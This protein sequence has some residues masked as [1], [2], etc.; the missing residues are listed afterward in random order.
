MKKT[1]MLAWQTSAERSF[2]TRKLGKTSGIKTLVFA[3]R[4]RSDRR[5][6]LTHFVNPFDQIASVAYATS[7][8]HQVFRTSSWSPFPTKWSPWDQNGPLSYAGG[9]A[10]DSGK[11]PLQ[12]SLTFTIIYDSDFINKEI[13]RTFLSLMMK[14]ILFS[15]N[16]S[17]RN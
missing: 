11:T 12:F 1:V 3:R 6:N 14:T 13:N 15:V 10:I 17:S 5:S 4:S 9:A 2:P 7:R 8:R 16:N